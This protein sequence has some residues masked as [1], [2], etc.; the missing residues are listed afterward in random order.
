MDGPTIASCGRARAALLVAAAVLASVSPREARADEAGTAS[1]AVAVPPPPGVQSF[2]EYGV[3]LVAEF[4]AA[5]GP[6]CSATTPACILGSGGGVALRAGWRP[7]ERV[8]VG[9]AYEISKQDPHELYRIALLQQARLEFRR[10]V[11]TGRETTPYFL[12]GA[13]ISGYGGNGWPLDTW[14][15]SATFGAGVELQLGKG[16]FE[17]SIA[18]R[19]TYL[20]SWQDT[21]TL[22]HEGGIAHFVTFE[23]AV[24]QLDAL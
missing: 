9:M 6:A 24:E 13:G 18:Y 16:V 17:M 1:A 4:V 11:P 12:V 21:S 20:R 22:F 3:A 14:G 10:Y 7:S 19:P 23:A 8:Y 15:P 5:P 2:F